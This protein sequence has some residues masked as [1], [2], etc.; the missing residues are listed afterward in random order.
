M[1]TKRGVFPKTD[2]LE[3]IQNGRI[4]TLEGFNADHVNGHVGV[5]SIDITTTGEAYRIE[6]V[7]QPNPRNNETVRSLLSSMGATSVKLGDTLEPNGSYLA[8]ASIDVNFPPGIYGFLNA[9]STSG[10]N[11]V[12][13]RSLADHIFMFDSVDMRHEGYTGELWLLIEPLAY[14][15]VLTDKECYTQMRVFNEDT[16]FK[17]GDLDLLLEKHD[18]L[19]RSSTK[20]AYQQGALSLFTHDG[21][22]LCT[23][24]AKDGHVGF[25][26][27]KTKRALDLAS[28]NV[29]PKE[30]FE[31]V[32]AER[33]KSED[34]NC[35]GV[36]LEAGD[37]YLFSTKE[38]LKVPL[39][40]TAELI[41]LDRRIGD[42]FTH[43]AGF[44]D[45][46]FFGTGTLEVQSPRNVFLRHKH[47]FARFVFEYLRSETE[48]YA[49]RGTYQEQIGAHLPKQFAAWE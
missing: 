14:P 12:H 32:Y 4:R 2:L 39:H 16:R 29:D 18:L 48:S 45:P 19:Y 36:Q 11:F 26:A 15:I 23:L 47:P 10:R 28:R 7:L 35:W 8:K 9:K 44:F 37:Y 43:F 22:V 42:I 25:R 1:D 13:V 38:M 34:E 30:Y 6:K 17:Q 20:E 41:G 3:L 40:V 46:G 31:P 33:F 49:A 24:H 5:A 27:K 21:S